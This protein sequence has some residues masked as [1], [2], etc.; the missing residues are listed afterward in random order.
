M[1]TEMDKLDEILTER[2]VKHTYDQ[3][4]DG[5]TQI[6]VHDGWLRVWDAI[7]TKSSYGGAQGLLEIMFEYRVPNVYG[8]LT[9]EQ[10]IEKVYGGK[11]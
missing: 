4:Y 6:I 11:K 1:K 7:C 3:N 8:C 10:V 5:G 2:G 9:A